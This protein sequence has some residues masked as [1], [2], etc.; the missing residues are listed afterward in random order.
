MAKSSDI[1][2]YT[3][4]ADTYCPEHIIEAMTSTEDFEGWELAEG[5]EM[6]VEENLDNMAAH[7]QIDRQE[8]WTFDHNEFPKVVY[9]DQAEDSICGF[10]GE[11]LS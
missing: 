7:F 4:K 1:V 2:G 8:E 6:A 3:F 5:I 10:D 11:P 9:R